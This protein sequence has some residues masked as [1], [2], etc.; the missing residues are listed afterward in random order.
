LLRHAVGHHAEMQ[1]TPKKK[2]ANAARNRMSGHGEIHLGNLEMDNTL[3]FTIDQTWARLAITMDTHVMLADFTLRT[4]A[5][6]PQS[7]PATA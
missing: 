6:L 7:L 1:E 4:F 2:Q 3:V 5:A